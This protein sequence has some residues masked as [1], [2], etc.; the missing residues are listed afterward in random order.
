VAEQERDRKESGVTYRRNKCAR[1]M[2]MANMEEG[3]GLADGRRV[4]KGGSTR[5]SER[6]IR[7]LATFFVVGTGNSGRKR[8]R[9]RDTGSTCVRT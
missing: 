5:E 2:L 4:K 8:E 1:V 7:T 9:D 3:S 6:S